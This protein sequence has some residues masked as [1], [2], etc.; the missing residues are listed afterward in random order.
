[1]A[2]F[3]STFENLECT[4]EQK[5]QHCKQII[6]QQS[7]GPLKPFNKKEIAFVKMI[8]DALF[9]GNP[10]PEEKHKIAHEFRTALLDIAKNPPIL[11]E[12][13]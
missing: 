7:I 13:R 8:Q 12:E 4:K 1:M 9:Q 2:L 10:T 5:R 3:G 11:E 6:E